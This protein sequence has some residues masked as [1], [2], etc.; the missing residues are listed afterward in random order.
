MKVVGEAEDRYA[1][2]TFATKGND[3]RK[4]LAEVR[5][6]LIGQTDFDS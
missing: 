6:F 4:A 2:V 5:P 1:I 3:T